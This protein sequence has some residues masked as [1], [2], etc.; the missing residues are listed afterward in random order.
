VPA[1]EYFAAL[2]TINE[3]E[4]MESSVA[5]FSMRELLADYARE[6]PDRLRSLHSYIVYSPY[7]PKIQ[8]SA[9][10]MRSSGEPI[11]RVQRQFLPPQ[12]DTPGP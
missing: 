10:L 7:G 3:L 9:N 5:S 1:A 12:L 4:N 2:S 11:E 6:C 8:P